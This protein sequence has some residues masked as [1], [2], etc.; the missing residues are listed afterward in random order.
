[1]EAKERPDAGVVECAIFGH[2]SCRSLECVFCVQPASAMQSAKPWSD[3]YAKVARRPPRPPPPPK[4]QR[5][6]PPVDT[7]QT[8]L[9]KG[10]PMPP[11]DPKRKAQTPNQ[12]TKVAAKAVHEI[13]AMKMPRTPAVPPVGREIV[14]LPP[15]MP[16]ANVSVVDLNSG[17]FVKAKWQAKI[18]CLPDSD[19]GE[20]S[21]PSDA[22]PKGPPPIKA[23]PKNRNRPN[24]VLQWWQLNHAIKRMVGVRHTGLLPNVISHTGTFSALENVA[25]VSSNYAHCVRYE[26]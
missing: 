18:D 4:R 3:L 1:M 6:P 23:M 20:S 12:S 2:R 25:H 24:A 22:M 9:P 16:V 10:F 15:D 7:E 17:P 5:Q 26:V 8:S 19:S 21:T 13:A 11:P 14:Q